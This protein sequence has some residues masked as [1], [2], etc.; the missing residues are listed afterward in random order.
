MMT[1]TPRRTR[2]PRSP[3]TDRRTP[4]RGRPESS[5][6]AQRRRP[7]P[8]RRTRPSRFAGGGSRAGRRLK[9]VGVV[10]AVKLVLLAV[11]ALHGADVVARG[12]E[13]VKGRF[14]TEVLALL[15]SYAAERTV[16]DRLHDATHDAAFAATAHAYR[17]TGRV[18]P[19]VYAD[20]A[21]AAMGD[22]ARAD[23][24]AALAAELD[25]LRAVAGTGARR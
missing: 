8:R 21:L 20:A 4:R 2:S 11:L 10:L 18:D 5:D 7:A 12:S 22:L 9:I 19:G 25:A 16:V 23:G 3:K 13:E 15:P 6:R 14:R 1:R 17:R 24:R